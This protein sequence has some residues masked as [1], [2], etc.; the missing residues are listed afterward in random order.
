MFE[1]VTN[2]LKSAEKDKVVKKTQTIRV[3]CCLLSRC[4][5]YITD[6]A[7]ADVAYLALFE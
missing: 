7:L 1:I 4:V 3:R 5:I 2:T 6:G